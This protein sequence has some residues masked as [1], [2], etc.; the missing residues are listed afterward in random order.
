[1]LKVNIEFINDYDDDRV[2]VRLYLP[3]E[4]ITVVMNHKV[5]YTGKLS[6]FKKQLNRNFMMRSRKAIYR[7]IYEDIL[8]IGENIDHVMSKSDV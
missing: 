4:R 7:K 5:V 3:A 8:H 1:M 6:D 2:E